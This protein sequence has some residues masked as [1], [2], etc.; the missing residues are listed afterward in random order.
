M[1]TKP[2][3]VVVYNNDNGGKLGYLWGMPLQNWYKIV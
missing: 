1:W 3:I 2:L